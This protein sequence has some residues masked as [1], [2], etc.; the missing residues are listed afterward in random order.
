MPSGKP[1]YQGTS[2]AYTWST[3]SRGHDVT[4]PNSSGLIPPWHAN[5][6][7]R[8]PRMSAGRWGRSC[9]RWR[10]AGQVGHGSGAGQAGGPAT[11]PSPGPGAAGAGWRRTAVRAW[12]AGSGKTAVTS[13]GRGGVT[14]GFIAAPG[15]RPGG[16]SGLRPGR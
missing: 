6:V 16:R 2:R 8:S 3:G 4:A 9:T 13:I 14:T 10:P 1:P 11:E 7:D 15:G 5:A 12:S